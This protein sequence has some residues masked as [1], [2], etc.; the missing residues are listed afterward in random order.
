[1]GEDERPEVEIGGIFSRKCVGAEEG[2]DG[3]NL[4]EDGEE[5]GCGICGGDVA[6]NNLCGIEVIRLSN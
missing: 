2:D 3:V 5:F 6:L 1:M 4:G